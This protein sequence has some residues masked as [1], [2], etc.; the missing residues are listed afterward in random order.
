[1]N[2]D[3][4][5]RLSEPTGR[6]GNIVSLGDWIRDIARAIKFG[7]VRNKKYRAVMR[8]GPVSNFAQHVAD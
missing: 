8:S 7:W 2:G 1:M 5:I 4:K 6:A 3:P